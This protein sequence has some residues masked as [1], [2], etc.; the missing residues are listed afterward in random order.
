[1]QRLDA[2][3]AAPSLVRRDPEACDWTALRL[4]VPPPKKLLKGIGCRAQGVGIPSF[5]A[6]FCL[7]DNLARN[8]AGGSGGAGRKDGG[9]EGR[10]PGW[11]CEGPAVYLS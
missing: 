10:G 3:A 8:W 9:G 11:V 1:M 4:R 7:P 2:A 5:R 6:P